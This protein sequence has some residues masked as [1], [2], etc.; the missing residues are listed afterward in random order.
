MKPLFTI[1]GKSQSI[2][3]L[4][5]PEFLGHFRPYTYQSTNLYIN[6]HNLNPNSPYVGLCRNG[7]QRKSQKFPT[8]R[9]HVLGPIKRPLTASNQPKHRKTLKNGNKTQVGRKSYLGEFEETLKSGVQAL[10]SPR[11]TASLLAPSTADGRITHD[12]RE[13][14]LLLSLT[15]KK[16]ATAPENYPLSRFVSHLTFGEDNYSLFRHLVT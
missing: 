16:S 5:E 14:L 8:I 11:R 13:K 1:P 12:S 10:S 3:S 9:S 7:Q 4:S 15:S 2:G 6:Q